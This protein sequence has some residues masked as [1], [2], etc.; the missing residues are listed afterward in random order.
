MSLAKIQ[1]IIGALRDERYRWTP[2]RRVY[3]D[4]KGSAKKRPLGL[5]SWSDKLLQEVI[6]SLLEAYYEPQFRARSHGFRPRRGCHTALQEIQRGWAG[7]AWFVEGDISQCFDRLDHAIMRGILAEKI[8]DNRF[9]RLIDGLLQAGYLE[10]WHHFATLSGSPQGGISTPP[11]QWITLA[12]VTLRIGFGVVLAGG[13]GVSA[14]WDAVPDSDRLRA[15]EDVFDQ[16]PEHALALGDA[17]GGGAVL[18]LGEEAFEVVCGL[19]GGLAVSG[20]GVG[21]V[22][23]AAQVRLP[24]AQVR[25]PGAKLVDGDQLLGEGLDHGGD[26]TGGPG[27]LPLPALPLGGGPGGGAGPVPPLSSLLA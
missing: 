16:E 25:H 9:L 22:D 8:H 15:D 12:M 14:G 6:R 17:G 7:T 13:R 4:K 18:Q 20:L 26:R 5:P 24:G 21:G 2:A 1:A 11:T 23:L 27:P 10:E 3:I 19:E